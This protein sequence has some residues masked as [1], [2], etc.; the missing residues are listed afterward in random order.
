MRLRSCICLPL[1]G[2]VE[3]ETFNL[4]GCFLE[5]VFTGGGGGK[6]DPPPPFKLTPHPTSNR[7][8]QTLRFMSNFTA[9]NFT[10]MNGV[11]EK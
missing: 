11:I 5:H 10:T 6:F 3:R 7:V 4:T 2:K 8:N 9:M 1:I